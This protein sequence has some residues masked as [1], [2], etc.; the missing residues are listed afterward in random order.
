M[1]IIV[2]FFLSRNNQ[3][4]DQGLADLDFIYMKT[5]SF[6]VFSHF[7]SKT[8]HLASDEKRRVLC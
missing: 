3:C 5:K 2:D 7:L 8:K 6:L 4:G 1:K